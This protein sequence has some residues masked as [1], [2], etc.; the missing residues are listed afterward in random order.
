MNKQ[1]F[2]CWNCDEEFTVETSSEEDIKFCPFCGEYM[3]EEID[4][5]EPLDWE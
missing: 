5:D 3:D 4:P 1:D 2:S